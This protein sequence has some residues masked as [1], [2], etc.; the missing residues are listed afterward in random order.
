MIEYLVKELVDEPE[1]VTVT[2]VPGEE[3]DDL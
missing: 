1:H 2:E 3:F